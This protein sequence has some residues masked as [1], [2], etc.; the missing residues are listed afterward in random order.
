MEGREQTQLMEQQIHGEKTQDKDDLF[1]PADLL[2][3]RIAQTNRDPE[4]I[5]R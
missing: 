3:A 5:P 4:V 1:V 2:G